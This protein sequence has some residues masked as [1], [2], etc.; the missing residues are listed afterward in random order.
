LKALQKG[1][2]LVEMLIA[3]SIACVF[4]VSAM[5]V[6]ANI[7]KFF[8]IADSQS[9]KTE[10]S[11][12][13]YETFTKIGSKRFMPKQY[14]SIDNAT[15]GALN[16]KFPIQAIDMPKFAKLGSHKGWI[17]SLID[18]QLLD[19]SSSGV[20]D[21][22][23]IIGHY[24]W[25]ARDSDPKDPKTPPLSIISSL[26][27]RLPLERKNVYFKP[28]YVSGYKHGQDMG[29]GWDRGNLLPFDEKIFNEL[30]QAKKDG[31]VSRIYLVVK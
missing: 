23:F 19:A 8:E 21:T 10:R 20:K 30:V 17:P 11:I 4:I 2:T 14:I 1:F 6:F 7:G 26:T 24:I 9:L 12:I 22:L 18:L 15:R 5:N 28:V 27:K 29:S 31:N 13:Y 16:L 3:A 25:Y